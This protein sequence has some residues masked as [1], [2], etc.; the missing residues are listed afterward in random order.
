MRFRMPELFLG[1]FL[2][3]AIFAMG[4]LFV[5]SYQKDQSSQYP[6][7]NAD[8]APKNKATRNPA[9]PDGTNPGQ[10]H[11]QQEAKSE[12]WSAKLSDW[13]LVAFTGLLVLFTYRLWQSTD[14]LWAA[15]EKQIHIA[16][17]TAQAAVGVEIP[18]LFVSDL[19]FQQPEVGNLG[20]HLQFPRISISVKNFGRTPAFL[21]QQSSE[22]LV[23][24]FLPEIPVYPN[25]H[26]L[27]PGRIIEGGASYDLPVARSRAMLS[28]E[29]IEGIL[30]GTT[31]VWVYGYVFYRD[32]LHDPH[33]LRFCGQLHI[34]VGNGPVRVIEEG[35][36]K[37]TES[38]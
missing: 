16:L 13:A 11:E 36:D 8:A 1:A 29:T 22:L 20:A 34:S 3:V 35:P 21:G 7:Q 14:K 2:A 28:R 27:E 32:F 38:Y 4:M 23:A 15:G 18:R 9:T 25:A 24:P 17:R 26:D 5:A 6:A 37:Y 33:W 12:F 19:Q 10:R 30:V 31:F